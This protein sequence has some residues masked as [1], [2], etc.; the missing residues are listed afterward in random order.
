MY[1]H[2]E[3]SVI[4]N[5]VFFPQTDLCAK[6]QPSRPIQCFQLRKRQRKRK[7]RKKKGRI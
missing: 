5:F 1:F 2:F 3:E 7:E 6:N 4:I